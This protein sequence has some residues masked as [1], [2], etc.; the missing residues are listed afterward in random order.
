M[1]LTVMLLLFVVAGVGHAQA[2]VAVPLQPFT[3]EAFDENQ[4]YQ[5]VKVF[6]SMRGPLR[7]Q[8]L[9]DRKDD[10]KNAD[11]LKYVTKIKDEPKVQAMLK[12][13]NLTWNQFTMLMGNILIAYL[14]VQ[15]KSTKLATMQRLADYGLG[16]SGDEIVNTHLEVLKTM[17]ITP[18]GVA[19]AGLLLD[20]IVKIPEQNINIVRKKSRTLDQLFYTRFWRGKL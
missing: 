4:F 15:P 2:P 20:Q 11:P 12:D 16:V 1:R 14:N 7:S 3:I 8:I 10:F 13:N 9:K 5:F 17:P 6:S 18:E 19:L